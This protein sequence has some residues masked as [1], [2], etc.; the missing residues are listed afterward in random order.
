LY[1]SG[2]VDEFN[3]SVDVILKQKSGNVWSVSPDRSVYEPFQEMADKES[4]VARPVSRRREGRIRYHHFGEDDYG[5]IERVIQA[6]LKENGATGLAPDRVSISGVGIEAAPDWTD[7]YSPETYIGYRQAQNFAS[8]ENVHKDSI[9]VFSTQHARETFGER[10]G[11]ERV[12]ERQWRKR[13]ATGSAWQ[14][15]VPVPQPRP[16]PGAGSR[17]GRQARAVCRAIGWRRSR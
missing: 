3:D 7:E 9:Q 10:L 13:R 4:S 15:R 5:E 6:L 14:D 8:P 12:V 17:E 11:I 16:Q 1:P 2:P